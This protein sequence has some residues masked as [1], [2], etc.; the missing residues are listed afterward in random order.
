MK[1]IMKS[2]WVI[3]ALVMTASLLSFDMK[4][5]MHSFQVFVDDKMILERYAD[6]GLK[7]PNVQLSTENKTLDVRYNECNRTVSGRSLT[8]KDKDDNVLKVWRYEGSTSGFKDPMSCSV[9]DLQALAQKNGN[10][11]RIYY[12][13]NDFPEGLHIIT[14]TVGNATV[15]SGN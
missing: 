10:A 3:F 2:L 11:V 7:A 13:S 14:A 4:P 6:R 8:A 9:K 1:Q 15:A 5:G 12:A